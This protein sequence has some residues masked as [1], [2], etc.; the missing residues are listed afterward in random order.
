MK[1]VNQRPKPTILRHILTPYL[2][3]IVV[4]P[5]VILLVVNLSL[6]AYGFNLARQQ[7]ANTFDSVRVMLREQLT[8]EATTLAK[9]L[10]NVSRMIKQ[11]SQVDLVLIG[12]NGRRIIPKDLGGT[13]LPEVL[14]NRIAAYQNQGLILDDKMQPRLE[15][16]QG[17]RYLVSAFKLPSPQVNSEARGQIYLVASLKA[18]DSFTRQLNRLFIG[19]IGLTVVIG[20]LAVV[21]LSKRLAKPI[22]RAAEQAHAIRSGHY[23]KI[24]DIAPAKELEDLY[25]SLNGMSEAL[26]RH[27]MERTAYFQNLSH[28]LRTPLMSIQ[29]YAEGIRTGVLSDY[30]GAAEVIGQESERLKKLVDGLLTLSKLDTDG[31]PIKREAIPLASFMESA[32]SRLYQ[33]AK[34]KGVQLML[35]A[36]EDLVIY[37][38][39]QLL[40][41]IIE[42]L[43]AN[44]I[45]YA[46]QIV[47]IDIAIVGPHLRLAIKDDGPGIDNK[48]L[49]RLFERFSKGADGNLGLGL[50][51]VKSAVDRLGG[52]ITGRNLDRGAIF[53]VTGLTY[54]DQ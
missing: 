32:V 36:P 52:T 39:E 45:R 10:N 11:T 13:D 38:D 18:L 24:E 1:R 6:R 4:L 35:N 14:L 7:I 3:L 30:Q 5:V 50:A 28:D 9:G 16:V 54:Q 29:G 51:I 19:I 25:S 41:T 49:P 27:D 48:V 12:A 20:V 33:I 40:A 26:E 44:A 43:C 17:T 47:V 37:T 23:K 34:K 53:E 31:R 21:V 2:A 46:N 15:R 22:Q 8:V 42:N